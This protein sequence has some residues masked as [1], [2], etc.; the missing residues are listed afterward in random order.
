MRAKLRPGKVISVTAGVAALALI[1]YQLWTHPLGDA[2]Q[3]RVVRDWTPDLWS[4]ALVTLGV[5]AVSF[6]VALAIGTVCGVIMSRK[7]IWAL[8]VRVYV[9]FFRGTPLLVQIFFIYYGLPQVGLVLNEWVAAVLALGLNSGAYIAEIVRGALAGID[10]GQTD[11]A[12]ALGFTWVQALVWVVIPQALRTATPPL[13][14]AI[15]SLLKD[16]SLL[17]VIAI[18]ELMYVANEVYSKTFRAFEI[19]AVVAAIYFVM[20]FAFSMLSKVLER[21]LSLATA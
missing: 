6:V 21:R 9:E 4:A 8:P 17:S 13:V 14:N 16:T 3:W 5:A 10:R 15:S 12:H 2:V 7:S 11:A 1:A 19:Y 20:T 18:T